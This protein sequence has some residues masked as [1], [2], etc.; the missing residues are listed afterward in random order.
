MNV[1]KGRE[2]DWQKCI[3]VNSTHPYSQAVIDI[4]EAWTASM[5]E[6]L[7]Q[8]KTV[9][10]CA[11]KCWDKLDINTSGFSYGCAA[12][13]IGQLW[14]HGDEFNAWR[15]PNGYGDKPPERVKSKFNFKTMEYERQRRKDEVKNG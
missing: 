8:G 1:K 6:H 10:E 4:I 2:A 7:A 11:E 5:E 13:L 14:V 3:E 15:N 12:S 9:A